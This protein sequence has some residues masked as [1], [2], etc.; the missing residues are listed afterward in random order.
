MSGWG[1]GGAGV[2]LQAAPLGGLDTAALAVIGVALLALV[3]VLFALLLLGRRQL[4]RDVREIVT[5]LEQMRSGRHLHRPDVPARSPVSLVADAVNRLGQDVGVRLAD[6]DSAGARLRALYDAAPD[7]AVLT[8]DL[9]GVVRTFNE[10]AE[11]LFGWETRDVVGS[12]ASALFDESAWKDLLPKM[13]RRGVR[14]RGLTTEAR[15]LRRDR[16]AID[17]ELA[18]RPLAPKS[19]DPA[20][21][22]VA[23]RDAS[24]RVALRERAAAAEARYR[25]LIERLGEGV[26]VLREGRVATANPA[27]CALAGRRVEDLLGHAL[28]D[29]VATRDVLAVREWLARAE[30]GQ[31][32]AGEI[33]ARLIGPVG[34]TTLSARLRAARVL[35]DGGAAVA[36]LVLDE[37]E[38]ERVE[39]ELRS[40]ERRLDAVLEATSDGVLVLGGTAGGAIVHLTNRAFLEMFGL[41]AGEVLG[42]SEG[43]LLKLLRERGGGAEAV[44]AFLAS[45]GGEVQRDTVSIGGERGVELEVNTAPLTDRDDRVLGR[46]VA[47]RDLSDTRT[48]ERRLEEQAGVLRAGMAELEQSYRRLEEFNEDLKRRTDELDRFNQEL[49][50]LDQ[51]KSNLLANV[52]H[53][54]QT[55]LVSIRGYTEMILR[56][57][58]GPTTEEQRRGLELS[59]RNVDRLISMIDG[60]LA[61]SRMGTEASELELSTFRLEEMIDECEDLLRPRLE[62]KQLEWVKRVDEPGLVVE[63]DRDKIHQVFVNLANNA[64]KYNRTGGT[65]EVRARRKSETTAVVEIRDTGVGIPKED[66][67]RIFDRFYRVEGG[68]EAAPEG[69][70]L[71]LSIVRNIL[72]LHGCTIRAESE[73]GKGTTIAFTLPLAAEHADR[74]RGPERSGPDAPAPEPRDAS[75]PP[76]SGTGP[77]PEGRPRLRI[78]RP[79]G[80]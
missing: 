66:L 23:V 26:V 46:I 59:L 14:E 57:R 19:G 52:S 1:Q 32:D 28:A 51:M 49:R 38:R 31:E 9:E 77:T 40:N 17:A 39:A 47:C 56:G 62:G 33:R 34:G 73:P 61:F 44:A 50:K 5:A 45:A 63:A 55:P 80:R 76:P 7:T 43:R 42:A 75:D 20:G 13:L 8:T 3:A 60:L 79:E 37:T 67:E 65:V 27:L 35:H 25:E 48:T 69:T 22:L 72:R 15:M 41:R 6:A 29:L 16:G 10:A 54:L 74:A 53:E 21:F 78:I 12:S 24:E 64:I 18:I 4:I 11:R 58:L 70:G 30:A 71:G 2:L 68:P 36:V